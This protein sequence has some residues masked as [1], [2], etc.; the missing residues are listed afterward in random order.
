MRLAGSGGRSGELL[1]LVAAVLGVRLALLQGK[2]GSSGVRRSMSRSILWLRWLAAVR[3]RHDGAARRPLACG[4]AIHLVRPCN[5]P[6]APPGSVVTG[7]RQ[8]EQ[9]ASHDV[10]P[11][12][13]RHRSDRKAPCDAAPSG[14][15]LGGAYNA[16]GPRGTSL[17]LDPVRTGKSGKPPESLSHAGYVRKT[18]T[19]PTVRPVWSR[20]GAAPACRG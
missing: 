9:A 18:S 19:L 1:T 11:S 10:V 6:H 20:V 12:V 5:M 13:V 3:Q 17:V 15:T 8:D 14:G 7:H 2:D 16:R 4:L